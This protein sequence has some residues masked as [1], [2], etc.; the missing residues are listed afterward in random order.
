M[1][2]QDKDVQEQ[3]QGREQARYVD[4]NS[5]AASQ[6]G[7]F[8]I[9]SVET[10]ERSEQAEPATDPAYDAAIEHSA[11]PAGEQPANPDGV[12]AGESGES[13]EEQGAGNSDPE[14]GASEDQDFSEVLEGS[15][16]D[17]ENHVRRNPQ[18]KDAIIAAEQK[19]DKPRK[20]VLEL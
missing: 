3:T 15:V 11:A 10:S 12:N 17:V 2:D 8:A 16:A 13:A 6:P 5:G 4:P 19:R 18:D 9:G 14:P 1:T 7:G 20:G